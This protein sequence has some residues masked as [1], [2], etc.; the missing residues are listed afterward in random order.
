MEKNRKLILLICIPVILGIFF[1]I[2]YISVSVK[3]QRKL[4]EAERTSIVIDKLLANVAVKTIGFAGNLV[5][6]A[7]SHISPSYRLNDLTALKQGF[8]DN[9]IDFLEVNLSEM[10]IRLFKDWKIKEYPIKTKGNPETWGGTA[11]G[12]YKVENGFKENYSAAAEA[13]MPY[14][15]KFYGKYFIHGEPYYPGGAKLISSVSGGCL[16]LRDNDAEDLYDSVEFKMPLL[17]IDKPNDFYQYP[18]QV[19][20]AFPTVSSDGYLV[21]DLDSGFVF[22]E[23]NSQTERPIA[24][25]TKLMTALVISENINLGKSIIVREWM[26]RGHGTSDH[27]E[28]GEELSVIELF[29]LL[30]I[31]SSNNAAEVISYFLDREHTVRLMNEKAK[32]ILMASTTFKGPS[33]YDPGNISTAQDLYY[34]TRYILNVRPPIFKITR[35][36]EV[37]NF[38]SS[39]LNIDEL[40][41]KNVFSEDDTFV[42]GKTGF[43]EESRYNGLFVFRFKTKDNQ[44][45][46]IAI[47][48]LGSQYQKSLK[49]DTQKIYIWLVKNYF[50]YE[51]TVL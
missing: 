25:L 38:G 45:R 44:E 41:N 7:K 49:S 3:Q 26:L 1:C 29:Y 17:V 40:W 22:A 48:L 19:K 11:T 33:G 31:E 15:L 23:H 5:E 39:Q 20:E 32:S 18:R 12:L 51:K 34:L 14:A 42:G 16:R 43:I 9:K 46:N 28:D 35:G 2:F 21:A 47:I 6:L 24:S 36:E 4:E 27:L 10:K 13:Y 30:L 50:D 37:S 8:L